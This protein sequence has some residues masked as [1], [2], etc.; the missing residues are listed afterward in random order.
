MGEYETLIVKQDGEVVTVILNRPKLNL[1]NSQM[2]ED[3]IQVWQSLR[4]NTT[5]R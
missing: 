3:L 2:M 1:F 5:A 4:R